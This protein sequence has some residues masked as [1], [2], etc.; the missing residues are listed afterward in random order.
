[1]FPDVKFILE[2]FSTHKKKKKKKKDININV[3]NAFKV[4]HCQK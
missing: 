3:R 2:T 4:M 1:M